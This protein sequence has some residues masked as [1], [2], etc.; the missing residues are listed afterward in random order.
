M[1]YTFALSECLKIDATHSYDND[2]LL[3]QVQWRLF[4]THPVKVHPLSLRHQINISLIV[5]IL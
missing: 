3:R 4:R 1:Y 5:I 2:L